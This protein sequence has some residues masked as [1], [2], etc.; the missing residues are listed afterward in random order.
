MPPALLG[1][2]LYFLRQP[3]IRPIPLSRRWAFSFP[4]PWEQQERVEQESSRAVLAGNTV[5]SSVIGSSLLRS[6]YSSR[7][8]RHA[9]MAFAHPS[10]RVSDE[11]PLT[12]LV[13]SRPSFDSAGVVWQQSEHSRPFRNVTLNDLASVRPV[14]LHGPL[15]RCV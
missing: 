8:S 6:F 11:F 5:G 13:V 15:R 10:G 3:D 2:L 4:E 1:Q 12:E 7:L 9:L 14:E